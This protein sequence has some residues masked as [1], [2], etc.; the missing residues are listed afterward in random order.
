[1][2]A[3]WRAAIAS[4]AVALLLSGCVG[5]LLKSREA[6]RSVYLLSVAPAAGGPEIAAAVTV[7]RPRVR[8]GLDTESIAA[9]YPDRRLEHF[10]GARW[11]G[12][13]DKVVQNL[14]L[15]AFR[16][17]A[18]ARDVHTDDSALGSG[19]WLEIE[20]VDFQAEYAAQESASGSEAPTVHVQF[21][22]RLGAS[23]DHHLIAQFDADVHERAADNRMA[24][25][26]DAYDRAANAALVKI[27]AATGEALRP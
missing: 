19:Y 11:G 27:V 24:A 3:P 14:A 23:D 25:I 13:L 22:A 4:V 26:V 9:L 1:V 6:P 17:D 5:G 20:V 16:V 18:R 10:A 7:L 21:V 15:Q 2:S 8:P 12:P